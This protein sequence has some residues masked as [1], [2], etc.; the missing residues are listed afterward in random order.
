[1]STLH[2]SPLGG[3]RPH[4]EEL[5]QFENAEITDR[6]PTPEYPYSVKLLM[7]GINPG[8]WTAAVN[9]PFSHPGNRFWPSLD[10]AGIISPKIDCTAGMSDADEQRLE[11][12]GI[13]IT[14][15]VPR[16]TA[17]ADELTTEELRESPARIID[18]AERLKPQAVAVIGITAYRVAFKNNKAKLGQQDTSSIDGWPQD[19]QLWV[20]P[21]P[22][23]LNAHENID[24]LG[25]KWKAVW[26]SI[27]E[28]EAADSPSAS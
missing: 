16:A 28:P 17:R 3:R 15:L 5:T 22:S 7:V 1:M 8:L 12:L 10:R 11:D 23:G 2:P 19:V 9:A 20:V 21:Q 4:K 24:T 14:N 26:D 13:A 18:L 27:A 6:L 25:E